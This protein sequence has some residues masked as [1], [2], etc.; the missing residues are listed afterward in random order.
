ML[1]STHAMSFKN[2]ECNATI[3]EIKDKYFEIIIYLI[4]EQIL[5][6]KFGI[7]IT[8]MILDYYKSIHIE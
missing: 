2:L 4:T 3:K 6:H 7:D 5:K 8:N 1:P